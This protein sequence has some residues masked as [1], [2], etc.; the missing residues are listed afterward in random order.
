[1]FK[2]QGTTVRKD[3]IVSVENT[4]QEP[5]IVGEKG[6]SVAFNIG[7]VNGNAFTDITNYG[8]YQV[9][10]NKFTTIINP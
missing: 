6:F 2:K 4:Y 9:M 7:D 1:M 5:E 10:H 8:E 3:T